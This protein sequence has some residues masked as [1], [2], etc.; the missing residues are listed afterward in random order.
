MKSGDRFIGSS[1]P[2]SI[3][4]ARGKISTQFMR[5]ETEKKNHSA[6]KALE[7]GIRM[8]GYEI[9]IRKPVNNRTDM[10]QPMARHSEFWIG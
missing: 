1:L 4:S 8:G 6:K 10:Q 5:L 2:P 7:E 9:N 3:A